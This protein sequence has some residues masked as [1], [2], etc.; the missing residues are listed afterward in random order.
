MNKKI[1]TKVKQIINKIINNNDMFTI[2]GLSTCIYCKKTLNLLKNK[3]LQ[4]KYYDMDKYHQFFIKFLY[5]INE[6][7]PN[8]NIDL[9]HDTFPVIF[10]NQKFIGGFDELNNYLTHT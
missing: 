3:N 1:D 5:K 9:T 10:Y 7:K 8:F 6:L 4:F 2:F